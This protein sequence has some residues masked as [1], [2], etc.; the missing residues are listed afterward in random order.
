MTTYELPAA[1]VRSAPAEAFSART[2]LVATLAAP[3]FSLLTV[4]GWMLFAQGL[5]IASA[6]LT[7]KQTAGFFLQH[8]NGM[9]VGTLI[10]A[11]ACCFLAVWTAQMGI[12]LWRLEG[13]APV[14]AIS[15]IL[16]GLAIVVIVILN[17]SFWA[18]AAYRP[19]SI[20]PDIIQ[21]ENDA[22][23]LGFLFVGWPVLSLQMVSTAVVALRDRRPE[24]L[25]PRWLSRASLVGAAVVVTAAGCGFTKTGPLA[26][27][28]VLGYFLPMAIW[29]SWL[30]LHAWFM[31]RGL[32]RES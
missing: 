5:N 23:W 31:Y 19:G 8:Q 13:A 26:Y 25:F 32:R 17:C 18:A 22:A 4:V 30:N 11:V 20:S 2:Q 29:G 7:A 1:E 12:T 14:M 9:I 28:G 21:A 16:A 24:P 15:Q 27:D 6:S 3:I 10:F